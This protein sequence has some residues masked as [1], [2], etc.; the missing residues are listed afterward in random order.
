MLSE[1]PESRKLQK[2][3]SSSPERMGEL[4]H[5]R[6]SPAVR[7]HQGNSDRGANPEPLEGDRSQRW[8]Q[9]LFDEL[10]LINSADREYWRRGEE[11]TSQERAAFRMRQ[12][13][14]QDIRRELAQLNSIECAS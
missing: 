9:I 2:A 8:S 3:K 12:L 13:R 4:F 7:D 14:L 11:A 10:H 6:W 1:M 5:F